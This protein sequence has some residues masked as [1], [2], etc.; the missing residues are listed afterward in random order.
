MSLMSPPSFTTST[1]SMVTAAL[2]A[3]G[4]VDPHNG[5]PPPMMVI[6]PSV[7]PKPP[8]Q[9]PPQIISAAAASAAAAAAEAASRSMKDH[10]QQK[11]D[12]SRLLE[13][14]KELTTKRP[15][16]IPEEEKS[17]LA[18]IQ[19]MLNMAKTGVADTTEKAAQDSDDENSG[20][21]EK[22][23]SSHEGICLVEDP[24]IRDMKLKG[25]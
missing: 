15:L 5:S 8:F 16:L 18:D 4:P 12:N 14:P 10:Q 25:M 9:L 24:I 23:L 19:S 1:P 3:R 13:N 22:T 6:P 17:D 20:M 2:Q 11:E 7:V 21:D